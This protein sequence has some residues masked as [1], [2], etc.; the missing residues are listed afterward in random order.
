MLGKDSIS[1]WVFIGSLLASYGCLI[2]G[3]GLYSLAMGRRAPVVL[4]HLHIDLW[5]GAG[6][7]LLGGF[8]VIRFWPRGSKAPRGSDGRESRT[9]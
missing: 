1:I 8:Y 9:R 2:L 5:W 3:N 7:L 4:A 6:L